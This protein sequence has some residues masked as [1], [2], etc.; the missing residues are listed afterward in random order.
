M[1][2]RVEWPATFYAWKAG[3]GCPACAEG[4]P[5]STDAGVRF[6][7]AALVQAQRGLAE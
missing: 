5:D 6:F 3:E 2:R 4:R 7:A 1:V